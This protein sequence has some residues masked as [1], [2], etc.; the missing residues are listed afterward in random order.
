MSTWA[1]NDGKAIRGLNIF[2]D[3]LELDAGGEKWTFISNAL[4]LSGSVPEATLTALKNRPVFKRGVQTTNG[5]LYVLK[6]DDIGNAVEAQV[7]RQWFNLDYQ[8]SH[9]WWW[10]I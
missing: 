3:V 9:S 10:A 6:R 5:D 7:Y 1:V 8:S 2:G 4:G